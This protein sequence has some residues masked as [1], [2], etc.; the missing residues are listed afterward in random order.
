[1]SSGKIAD[2]IGKT[3]TAIGNKALR[4]EFAGKAM[5]ALLKP[6]ASQHCDNY[7]IDHFARKASVIAKKA[8][9]M[10]DEHA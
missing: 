6:G 2:A 3:N 8:Y 4:D 9:A 10:A 1:M 5:L 7:Y